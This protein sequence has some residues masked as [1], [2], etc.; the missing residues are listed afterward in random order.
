ML[1]TRGE[2]AAESTRLQRKVDH[3][4]NRVIQDVARANSSGEVNHAFTLFGVRL[5]HLQAQQHDQT[6]KR[7]AAPIPKFPTGRCE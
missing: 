4:Q 5:G 7:N 1:D 3:N 2:V 6:I